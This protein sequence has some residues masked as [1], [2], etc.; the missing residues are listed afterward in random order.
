MNSRSSPFQLVPLLEVMRDFHLMPRGPQRRFDAYLRLVVGGAE[1]TEDLAIAPLVAM[2]PMGREHIL[3][4]LEACIEQGVE[5]WVV[6]ALEDAAQRLPADWMALLPALKV[7]LVVVD[8]LKGG[9]TNHYF[10]DA[11]FRFKLESIRRNFWVSVPLWSTEAL[12]LERLR[13]DALEICARVAYFWQF[14]EAK[15]LLEHMAQEGYATAFAGRS[16][17]LGPDDLEYTRAVLEPHL[18]STHPPTVMAAL[19][20]D[21]AAQSLGYPPLGLSAQAGFE[22]ALWNAVNG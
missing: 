5:A 18:H 13:Q 17:T 8:D 19:Y 3:D 6:D 20:G 12:D 1:R 14:G 21:V 10:T 2:N 22:L 11:H 4:K 15:T 7:G 16:I 9:W